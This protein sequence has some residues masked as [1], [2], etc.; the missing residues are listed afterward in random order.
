MIICLT[1][2]AQFYSAMWLYFFPL[3]TIES[4]KGHREHYKLTN[5]ITNGDKISS[6]RDFIS[7]KSHFL[8]M[9]LDARRNRYL[10]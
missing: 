10:K 8:K 4:I 7:K 9:N 2:V 6:S 5:L 3:F 1:I